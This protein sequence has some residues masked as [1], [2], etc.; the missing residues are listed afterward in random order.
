MR[1]KT[2]DVQKKIKERLRTPRGEVTERILAGLAE[3]FPIPHNRASFIDSE[4]L[5]RRYGKKLG[6][7]TRK[8]KTSANRTLGKLIAEGAIS[9]SLFLKRE[10]PRVNL[11]VAG[12]V[13]I[14]I[15]LDRLTQAREEW[16]VEREKW[17]QD[18]EQ[19]KKTKIGPAP[20]EPLEPNQ[21]GII[22]RIIQRSKKWGA[23]SSENPFSL[24]LISISIVHGSS[25]FDLLV[26]VLFKNNDEYMQ[27]VRDV[28]Q[29]VPFVQ[30]THTM[31]IGA[32]FGFP[33]I[34]HA[35]I[36]AWSDEKI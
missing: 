33:E 6:E 5:T 23:R 4:A 18:Y 15:N 12:L 2:K 11:P 13:S 16:P 22:R 24:L 35:R 32:W 8:E 7:L 9:E 31:Q 36:I 1:K 34:G 17:K 25:D 10:D 19:W 27:Y 21:E 14:S 20:E 26:I 30:K 3:E 29:Q 28:I